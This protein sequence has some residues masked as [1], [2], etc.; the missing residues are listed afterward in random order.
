[1]NLVPTVE[2][3]RL[4]VVI[5]YV[6]IVIL[7]ICIHIVLSDFI[8]LPVII[9]AVVSLVAAIIS[10]VVVYLA[11]KLWRFTW[12]KPD[13]LDER[14]MQV[15]REAFRRAYLT[16]ITVGL[17]AAI[18]TIIIK[19]S[20]FS[21]QSFLEKRS[22]NAVPLMFALVHFAKTLPASILAWTAREIKWER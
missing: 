20:Y 2:T 4:G 3:R 16:T 11:P 21:E 9:F 1:M 7:L 10:F 5:H 17:I 15:N 19:N 22:Y 12:T 6:S 18:A 14:E 8:S 13:Q